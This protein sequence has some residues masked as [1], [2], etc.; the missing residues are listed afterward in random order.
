MAQSEGHQA[1]SNMGKAYTCECDWIIP[2]T[3]CISDFSSLN[4]QQ[5]SKTDQFSFLMYLSGW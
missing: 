2:F 4:I 1:R 3:F 5:I